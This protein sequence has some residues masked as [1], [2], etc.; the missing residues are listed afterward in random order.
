[1]SGL[2]VLKASGAPSKRTTNPTK[3]RAT[4]SARSS[5]LAPATTT[6]RLKPLPDSAQPETRSDDLTE[7]DW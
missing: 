6:H 2:E 3:N 1:M 5:W 4:T 7:L